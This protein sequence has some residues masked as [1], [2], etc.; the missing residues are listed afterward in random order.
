M[1]MLGAVQ[2]ANGFSG[3]GCVDM[4]GYDTII[5]PQTCHGSLIN[6]T[7]RNALK[8][9]FKC[10]SRLPSLSLNFL[11][12]KNTVEIFNAKLIISTDSKPLLLF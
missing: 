3:I 6:Q 11:S 7:T 1:M 2:L 10:A 8:C 4:T 12:S 9:G 5:R